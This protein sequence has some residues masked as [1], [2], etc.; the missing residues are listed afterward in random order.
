MN[1]FC[2]AH[3][4]L[5]AS[6]IF[7]ENYSLNVTWLVEN[8]LGLSDTPKRCFLKASSNLLKTPDS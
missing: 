8:N 5:S 3:S 1:I 7:C 6:S 2:L 4:L